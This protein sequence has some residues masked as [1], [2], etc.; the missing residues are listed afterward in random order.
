MS[1]ISTHILDTSL[2]LPA[3]GV[4]VRLERLSPLTSVAEAV[5]D[6]DGRCRLLAACAEAGTY[7]LTFQTGA[8]FAGQ[9]RA[10]LY[11]EVSVTFSVAGPERN[12]HLPLLINPFG[13]STYRGT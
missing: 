9:A 12:Y 13:Y 4:G 11:P 10:T 2:G 1:G 8:Y 7:R 5:T 3:R 6:A